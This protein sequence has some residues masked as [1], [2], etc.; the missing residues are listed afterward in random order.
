MKKIFIAGALLAALGV[1]QA[2]T[3]VTGV[4]NYDFTKQSGAKMATG[5]ADS[6][7]NINTTEDLGAVKVTA[8]LGLNGAGRGEE[9]SGTDAYIAILSPVGAVTVGQVEAANGL[10]ANTFGMAPVMGADGIVLAAKSNIDMVKY[11]TP[12]IAG[13]TGS[14][15][16]TRGVDST[17]E[18]SYV[19]GLKGAVGPVK[20]TADYTNT[21][22]R[23][24]VSGSMDLGMAQVGAGWSGN[25]TG[26]KNSWTVAS[27]V[28]VGP[29]TV[30]AAYSNG[31]GKA[32]ELGTTYALS[33]RTGVSAAVR[34]VKDNSVESNNSTDYRVRVSHSF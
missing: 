30:G 19:A 11:T 15:S 3:S 8:S 29:L 33:K 9:L 5:L 10:K 13:F 32:V 25:E 27:A 12:A 6:E 26:R 7:I 16:A 20:A 28:P 23:V 31:D 34:K 24:R 1:A 2:Q 22:K 18:H 21:S 14:V 4:I 17:G